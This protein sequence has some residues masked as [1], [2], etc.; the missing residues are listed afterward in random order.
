ML[1]NKFQDNI[2]AIINNPPAE[3]QGGRADAARDF[4][5]EE[6]GFW[7]NGDFIYGYQLNMAE[8]INEENN[9]ADLRVSSSIF[10]N[11]YDQIKV[12]VNSKVLVEKCHF[13]ECRNNSIYLSNP[14]SALLRSNT[15][16]RAGSNA[17][18]CEM[19][20]HS[21]W[22]DKTRKLMILKNDIQMSNGNGIL[23]C[24]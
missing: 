9:H 11:F 23:I 7:V 4:D 18:L 19:L 24:S 21:H 6:I 15:I 14:R 20:P 5:V 12:G 3:K 13:S 16:T 22:T 2:E 1:L 10:Y 17:I 8:M